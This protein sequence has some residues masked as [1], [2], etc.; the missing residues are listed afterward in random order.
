VDSVLAS[1]KVV[2]RRGKKS[3]FVVAKTHL[4]PLREAGGES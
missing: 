1:G 3:P 2:V 4:L